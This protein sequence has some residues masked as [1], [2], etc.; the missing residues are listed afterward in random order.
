MLHMKKTFAAM[1]KGKK[2]MDVKIF[3]KTVEPEAKAQVE[4][5]GCLFRGGRVKN[6]YYAGL[7]CGEGLHHSEN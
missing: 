6:P 1:E 2:K 3:A 4:K 5:N 7:P